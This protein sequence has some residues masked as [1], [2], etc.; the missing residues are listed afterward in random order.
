MAFS[1]AAEATTDRLLACVGDVYAISDITG[2][3]P[4]RAVLIFEALDEDG[5]PAV[6]YVATKG[7]TLTDLVGMGD[8]LREIAMTGLFA[9]DDEE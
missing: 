1:D 4:S 9:P 3:L 8:F 2:R 6:D 5:D 7:M